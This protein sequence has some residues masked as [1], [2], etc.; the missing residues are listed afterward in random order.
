[1]GP[2]LG[3]GDAELGA[4]LGE[5][6][7]EQGLVVARDVAGAFQAASRRAAKARCRGAGCWPGV[8]V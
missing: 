1:M 5:G 4:D 3:L 8:R 6:A 7:G 2:G